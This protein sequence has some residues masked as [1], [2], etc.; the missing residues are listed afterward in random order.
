MA[1][2]FA[3]LAFLHR[4]LMAAIAAAAR[5]KITA[6]AAPELTMTAWSW[7]N[8]GLADPPLFTAIASAAIAIL[9]DFG[10]LEIASLL[11]S[12]ALCHVG[13]PGEH[14]DILRALAAGPAI[15]EGGWSGHSLCLLAN[16]LFPVRGSLAPALWS[17]VD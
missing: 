11:W 6:F 14:V 8:L 12:M 3:S 10:R 9:S 2:A 1:W 7:S 13:D 16:A 4:P 5:A 15:L 17:R